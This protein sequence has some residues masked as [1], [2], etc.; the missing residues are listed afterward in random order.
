MSGNILRSNA[1]Y[2]VGMNTFDTPEWTTERELM[3]DKD[4][5]SKQYMVTDPTGHTAFTNRLITLRGR[6]S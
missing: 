6:S 4:S 1:H 5:R 3:G 2:S